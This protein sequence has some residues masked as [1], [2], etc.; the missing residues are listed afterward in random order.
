MPCIQVPITVCATAAQCK[1]GCHE[2]AK[3]QQVV[4]MHASKASSDKSAPKWKDCFVRLQNAIYSHNSNKRFGA[5]GKWRC[6]IL[7]SYLISLK[8]LNYFNFRWKTLTSSFLL[9]SDDIFYEFSA[10]AFISHANKFSSR[11]FFPKIN[12]VFEFRRMRFVTALQ[13]SQVLK[14][15]FEVTLGELSLINESHK[16]SSH[17]KIQVINR[18]SKCIHKISFKKAT[19]TVDYNY[20]LNATTIDFRFNVHLFNGY[21]GVT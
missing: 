6:S 1:S 4:K 2:S 7:L 21:P 17:A 14:S 12:L 16:F 19:H 18:G 13:D 20:C 3:A 5:F 11:R 8:Q 15:T 10:W 9:N